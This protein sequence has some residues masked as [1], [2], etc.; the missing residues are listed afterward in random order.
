MINPG[1]VQ[2]CG[3]NRVMIAIVRIELWLLVALK[4]FVD[5]AHFCSKIV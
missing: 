3:Q 2:I 4:W 5:Y 1:S